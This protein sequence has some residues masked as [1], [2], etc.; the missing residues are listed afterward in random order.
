MYQ[1]WNYEGT[2]VMMVVV[3]KKYLFIRGYTMEVRE[4]L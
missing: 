2:G 4:Q 1:K 3:L